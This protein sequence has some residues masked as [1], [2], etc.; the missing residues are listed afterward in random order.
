M[1]SIHARL[2]VAASVVLVAFL[3]LTGLALDRAFRQSALAA[4]QERLRTQI[5]MLL[6]VAEVAD[7]GRLVLP[8]ALHE[9]RF[10]TPGSG[11][12]ARVE[13]AGGDPIWRSLSLLG[14]KLPGLIRPA[15]GEFRFEQAQLGDAD[16]LFVLGFTVSWEVAPEVYRRFTFRVAESQR[17]FYAQVG[18]FRRSLGGWLLASSLVLLAVQGLILRW[19]L[20][21]L[22]QVTRELEEVETGRRTELA[23]VYPRELQPLTASLNDFIRHSRSHLE[24]YRN[25]L[26]DLA[27]SLKTPLAVLRGAVEG[28]PAGTAEAL[29]EA[30]R[31]QVA[32]MDR[33]VQYQLQRAA[34]SG[35][36]ALAAPIAVAPLAQ[37]VAATLG[38]VY[39]DKNL[40]LAV[41][42]DEQTVFHG[43]EGDLMEILGN[44]ADNACKWGRT[45]VA[46]RAGRPQAGELVVE[47][48]DDG[49]G[50]P[51]GRRRA[52][53][54]RGERADP[55]T[56]GHGIG[57]AVV[58]SLVEEVYR[59]RLEIDDGVWGGARIRARLWF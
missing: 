14:L 18:G 33:T 23:G 52:I 53:L 54:E 49:P 20:K 5:Y 56:P 6:G 13:D 15:P 31:E 58:R 55:T 7:G 19:S 40:R 37:R 36:I 44:L 29:R 48:E 51:A 35:R 46:L 41:E 25:A 10:S 59:G 16:P 32:R 50:I 22:R 21:P 38:K 4:E 47:V 45:R 43:D 57:L 24:R 1:I 26:G 28:A 8:Q 39:G 42:I 9:V 17:G 27:H 11:L 34:A 12:Y 2:L 3:G 30:V